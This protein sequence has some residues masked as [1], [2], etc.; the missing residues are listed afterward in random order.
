MCDKEEKKLNGHNGD[1]GIYQKNVITVPTE[2]DKNYRSILEFKTD[3]S[4][5]INSKNH[6]VVICK[7]PSTA[8]DK[9]TDDTTNEIIR[10]MFLMGYKGFTLLN[11][12][13]ERASKPKQL[14][15]YNEKYVEQNVEEIKKYLDDNN[16]ITE[17]WGAWGDA[18]GQHL[19]S[20]K[21]SLLKV[22]ADK[23]IDIFY[24]G[25]LT[26]SKNPCHPLNLIYPKF[27]QLSD[28]NY[29]LKY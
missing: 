4:L 12:Y 20:G 10:T 8:T 14:T 26:K 15:K 11:I 17:I 5:T 6:L 19:S 9:I 29:L 25:E 22:L 1:Y 7:N 18:K 2:Y 27:R 23:K 13:P 3:P 24:F 16:E 28:K 21:E